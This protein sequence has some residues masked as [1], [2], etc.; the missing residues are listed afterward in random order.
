V[1]GRDSSQG[2]NNQGG[3]LG[4]KRE[5]EKGK[6]LNTEGVGKAGKKDP[7]YHM[8]RPWER[9]I[10]HAQK[11]DRGNTGFVRKGETM[12]TKTP[13]LKNRFLQKPAVKKSHLT[14]TQQTHNRDAK[15]K[16]TW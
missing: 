12:V 15:K 16:T 5:P 8:V 7:G 2:G 13:K 6:W 4:N 3:D 10:I 9:K 11:R 14:N 1:Q